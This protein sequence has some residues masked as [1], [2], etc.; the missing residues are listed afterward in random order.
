MECLPN[1]AKFH[2]LDKKHLINK[3]VLPNKT[4]TYPIVGYIMDAILVRGNFYEAYN[5]WA[6]ISANLTKPSLVHH[7]D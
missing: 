4:W 5:F 1:K 2:F 6:I 3:D 7:C